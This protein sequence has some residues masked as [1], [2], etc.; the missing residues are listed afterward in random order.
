VRLTGAEKIQ[1]DESY[2]LKIKE[3]EIMN[4]V[5]FGRILEVKLIEDH[6]LT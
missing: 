6:C 2:V 5:L 1:K 3:P 4:R